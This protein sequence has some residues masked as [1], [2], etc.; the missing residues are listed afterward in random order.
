MVERYF[1]DA[2]KNDYIHHN[3]APIEK[4]LVANWFSL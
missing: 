1:Y 4:E 3:Q 2:Q